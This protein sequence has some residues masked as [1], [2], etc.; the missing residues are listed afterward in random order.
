MTQL[1]HL[2]LAVSDVPELTRFFQTGLGFRVLEQRGSGK[3]AV[4]QGEDGFVLIL[5]H[6]KTVG[7]DT[8]PAQF[9]VG[10]LVSTTDEVR[11][12]HAGIRDAG[13]DAPDPAVLV[14][15]LDRAFGFY[16]NAP[17]GVMVEVSSRAL[18]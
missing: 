11:R 1:N 13:F 18:V 10:F 14:R 7:P 4:M 6:D 17:G 16:S 8:Y 3:F 12:L 9:H 2:N 15:G 5:M